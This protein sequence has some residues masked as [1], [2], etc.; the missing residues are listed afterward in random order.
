M[1]T[2]GYMLPT[3]RLGKGAI[4]TFSLQVARTRRFPIVSNLPTAFPEWWLRTA[5]NVLFHLM[6]Y[7]RTRKIHMLN[8]SLWSYFMWSTNSRK[9]GG[10]GGGG[11]KGGGVWNWV[12]AK[13]DVSKVSGV[14][15]YFFN[16]SD[17]LNQPSCPILWQRRLALCVWNAVVRHNNKLF[18]GNIWCTIVR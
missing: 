15:M 10:G 9:R 12:W 7:V 16:F 11:G 14:L 17:F 4:G 3:N 5:C 2:V 8:L 18:R 1:C 6:A 13:D